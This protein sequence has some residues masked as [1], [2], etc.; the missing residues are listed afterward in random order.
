MT[1]HGGCGRSHERGREGGH[2]RGQ[3]GGH[4]RGLTPGGALVAGLTGGIASGKSTVLR[5]FQDA[6]A[7]TLDADETVHQLEEPGEPVYEEIVA[8]FGPGFVLPD[9]RLDRRALGRL[10]FS[11]PSVRERL[12]RIVHPQV[13]ERLKR[14]ITAAR[15]RGTPLLVVDVPLLFEVGFDKFVDRTVVVSVPE[16]VQLRRLME[17]DGLDEASARERL[18]AQ[19]PLA[20]KVRRADHVIDNGGTAEETRAQVFELVRKW[21]AEGYWV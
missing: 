14:E 8:E 2:E 21:K 5:F 17:R 4:G 15:E 12:D 13:I 16:S 7:V 1:F 11:E 3:E 9:G 19:W 10:V 18:A 20:E 6:G